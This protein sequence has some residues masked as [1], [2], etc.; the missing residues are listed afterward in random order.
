MTQDF[1]LE[2]GTEPLPARFVPAGL[3]QLRQGL[4]EAL[5]RGGL[6]V[7]PEQ[8]VC[9][10]TPLRLAL[11][12]RGLPAR[13]Q[14]RVERVKGPPARLFKDASGALTPQAAGFAN[15]Q[16]V[17]PEALIVEEGFLRAQVV[18]PGRPTSALLAQAVPE[19]LR[20]IE[21]PKSM[22]WEASRFRFGRPIRSLLALLGA[23]VVPIE[24]AGL[25]AGRRIW[26]L[27]VS[28]KGPAGYLGALR[29]RRVLGDIKERREVLLKRLSGA[30]REAGGALDLDDSLLEET[31]FMT[32][33]PTPVVGAFP[34][35]FLQVPAPLLALVLKKQLKFF[36]VRERSGRLLPRFVG[37]RDGGQEGQELV[38]EGYQRVLAARGNDAVFFFR[39]DLASS[40]EAKRPALERVTY[41]HGLGSMAQRSQRLERLAARLCELVRMEHGDV[42]EACVGAIA[43][44]C[45]A[46]LVTEVVKEFPELQGIMGGVYA[47]RDGLGEKVAL[48]LEQFYLPAGPKSP[49]PATV[50]AALAGLAGRLDALAGQFALGNVPSGSA[51]PFALRRQAL[52]AL[53]IVLERQLPLDL[54]AALDEALALQPVRLEPERAREAAERLRDFLL[55]RLQAFL[56]EK[57]YPI[58]EIRSVREGSLADLKRACLRLATL[59]SLRREPDFEPLAAA[60][61]RASNILK[62]ARF[63]RDGARETVDRGALREPAERELC[64]ALALAEGALQERLRRD[65]YEGGLRA[66]SALKPQLDRF[67]DSVMVMVEDE[68]LRRQRLL[69]LSRLS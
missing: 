43:R 44:L 48:G 29:R 67:F 51:D 14:D 3:E 33:Q 50:E 59:H 15:K 65:D 13:S 24:L 40:L 12:L 69:L 18:I 58:D 5:R 22:E 8:A 27:P 31:V 23:K 53:R 68:A 26:G 19:A 2:V 37:V 30:E 61:K 38:R 46:D 11:L 16:G 9:F 47:R 1:L 39:R 36:P 45:L 20:G 7:E 21:F 35:D 4:A 28:L 66:L 49:T 41:Q 56:E 63:T 60:F 32:E 64:D 25:R 54:G 55:G 52:G 6:P 57:G 34:D 62:Q 17:P 10:G 42:D